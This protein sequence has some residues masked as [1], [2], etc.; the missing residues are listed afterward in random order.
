MLRLGTEKG[1]AIGARKGWRRA[2]T[3]RRLAI[4]GYVP[5]VLGMFAILLSP[6][7]AK[8]SESAAPQPSVNPGAA[9]TVPS[10]APSM[11]AN[12]L[13]CLAQSPLCSSVPGLVSLGVP[14][15]SMDPM[16]VACLDCPFSSTD[17]S[18]A[19]TQFGFRVSCCG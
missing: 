5:I 3:G 18:D 11:R 6:S 8:A 17:K 4:A 12:Q 15:Q 9:K 10:P 16:P 7:S 13:H 14:S 2:V 19:Q 1:K